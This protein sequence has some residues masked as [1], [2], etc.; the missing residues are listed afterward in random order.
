M[1]K[2]ACVG[3]AVLFL[4]ATSVSAQSDT[5]IQFPH[6]RTK[7]T[8]EGKVD[9]G[10]KGYVLYARAG[11]QLVV[12]LSSPNQ[13][14]NFGIFRTK[15]FVPYEGMEDPLE[16]A[17][18]VR[19]WSGSLREEGDYHIMVYPTGADP[20]PF[21]LEVSLL[22]EKVSAVNFEGLFEPLGKTPKGFEGL[23]SISLT[24]VNFTE[25]GAVPIKPHGDVRAGGVYKM[26]RIAIN[27]ENLTFETLAVRGVSYSFTGKLTF[28][29]ADTPNDPAASLLKGN[30][31]KSLNGK[32]VAEAELELESVEGV[33]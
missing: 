7:V 23:K 24:T 1:K 22:S 25:N 21:T 8:L 27:G 33:D 3:F 30:L 13:A 32:K 20:T 9:G 31:S 4:S 28:E 12:H 11:Q 15:Y 16:G 19:D 18:E 2:L 17:K 26:S 6:G 5:R 14:E 29:N 10:G